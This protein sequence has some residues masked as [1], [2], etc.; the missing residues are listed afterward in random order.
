MRLGVRWEFRFDYLLKQKCPLM[1]GFTRLEIR[2]RTEQGWRSRD[3]W[4]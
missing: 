2:E 4:L 1:F 3:Q